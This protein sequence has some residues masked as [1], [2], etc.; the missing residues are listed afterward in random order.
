[1][2]HEISEQVIRQTFVQRQHIRSDAFGWFCVSCLERARLGPNRGRAFLLRHR[3][4]DAAQHVRG[5]VFQFLCDR[6]GITLRGQFFAATLREIT[7][8]RVILRRVGCRHQCI[9]SD[10]MVCQ[11][12]SFRRKKLSGAA[13]HDHH[14]I[15]NAWAIRIV[16]IGERNFQSALC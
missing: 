2:Q 14:G 6:H 16:N 5:D 1:M 12:Q 10:V 15:L 8:R 11:E 4:G 9:E 13:V 7:I 3:V